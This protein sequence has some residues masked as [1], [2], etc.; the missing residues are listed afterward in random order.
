[1]IYMR[2]AKEMY[3][4]CLDHE[5]IYSLDKVFFIKKQDMKTFAFIEQE[6]LE[7]DEDVIMCFMGRHNPKS[8]FK[9]DGRFIYAITNKKM[10]MICDNKSD[11]LI[12]TVDVDKIN[13]VILGTG[14]FNGDIITIQTSQ[15]KFSIRIMVTD[16]T[17]IIN[18]DIRNALLAAK[19]QKESSAAVSQSFSIDDLLK[20]KQ[21]LDMGAITQKEFD[22][23]KKQ[24][25]L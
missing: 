4:Y 1:M 20:L 21:L 2:T 23:A 19:Q 24:I 3:Q 13:D 22:D 18:D 9:D 6:L 12:H 16:K 14:I 10:I 7:E 17:Q 8:I 15:I 5:Y 11:F 25:L